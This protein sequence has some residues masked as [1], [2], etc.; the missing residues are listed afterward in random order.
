MFNGQEFENA[1]SMM[2]LSGDKT[3]TIIGVVVV[4]IFFI[5][6]MSLGPKGKGNGSGK[7]SGGSGKPTV[8]SKNDLDHA[9]KKG[10]SG[11][12]NVKKRY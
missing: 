9:A 3:K 10:N 11:N 6:I 4:I 1:L 8:Y 12:Q 2:I 5:W 7:R